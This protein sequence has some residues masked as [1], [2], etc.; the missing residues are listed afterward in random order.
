MASALTTGG[1]TLLA[2]AATLGAAIWTLRLEV[3]REDRNRWLRFQADVIGQADDS[4]VGL[5]TFFRDLVAMKAV[6]SVAAEDENAMEARYQQANRHAASADLD[7]ALP[8]LLL[9]LVEDETVSAVLQEAMSQAID[10]K[11]RGPR[12]PRARG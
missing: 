3:D 9:S 5:S 1:A 6:E 8:S 4:V 7:L 2:V 10:F 11:D 12:H